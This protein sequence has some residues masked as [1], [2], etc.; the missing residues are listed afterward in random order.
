MGDGSSEEESNE[1]LTGVN[2]RWLAGHYLCRVNQCQNE[3][4]LLA[5]TE[6]ERERER[7]RESSMINNLGTEATNVAH[8]TK[9]K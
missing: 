4:P 5:D 6:R 1:R 9:E 8:V 2:V 7:E 3:P